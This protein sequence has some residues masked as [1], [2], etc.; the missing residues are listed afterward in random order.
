MTGRPAVDDQTIDDLAGAMFDAD[1]QHLTPERA[2]EAWAH[3]ADSY[4]HDAQAA[5]H[6]LLSTGWTPPR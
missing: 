6:H 4:R 3:E 5:L 2:A 1:N